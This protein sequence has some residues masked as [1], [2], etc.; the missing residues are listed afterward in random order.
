M[1][2]KYLPRRIPAR[3][4]LP[5]CGTL[6]GAV[7]A[8]ARLLCD[9]F[10][11]DGYAGTSGGG[12]VALKLAQGATP[13]EVC[14]LVR[15]YLKRKDLLDKGWL[16]LGAT[17]IYRG[18]VIAGLLAK[19][20]GPKTTLSKLQ[21][22]CRVTVSSMWTE[23]SAVLCSQR[24]PEVLAWRAGRA[25]SSIQGVFDLVRVREDNSRTYGDG[26]LGLNV[27]AGIWDDVDCV[28]VFVRFRRHEPHTIEELL[29]NGD[30]GSDPDSV[31]PVRNKVD[32]ARA[33][34]NLALNTA[35][36]SFPTRKPADRVFEII[37]DTDEDSL[38]F[39]LT[40]HQ[41]EKR[42][43]AGELAVKR[44]VAANWGRLRSLSG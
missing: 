17:G 42:E 13:D 41:I 30:G 5:G 11:F 33:C 23:R 16:T 27:P 14:N 4:V 8:A 34:V 21:Y 9:I 24:H 44:F 37:I 31:K 28:T 1:T 7:A 40:D 32:M 18:D 43:K 3:L 20:L 22:P 10:D 36:A 15:T 29:A 19:E 26:G 2:V 38:D 25:T 39:S 6:L 12:I 35:S